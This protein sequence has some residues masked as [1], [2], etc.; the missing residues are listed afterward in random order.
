MAS[1]YVVRCEVEVNGS[2]VTD[3]KGFTESAVTT[4]KPVNLMHST[5]VAKVTK[6]FGFSL[7]YVIPM[8][9]PVD[10]Y[11]VSDSTASVVY[12]NGERVDF[13]G[14][15]VTEVGEASTDGENEMV[16]TITFMAA[17]RNGDAE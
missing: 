1:R 16:Q 6:R 13:G 9:G 17:T 2:Q 3:F 14:V 5:G 12:D 4:A 8:T 15:E 7:Q 11:D 10:W